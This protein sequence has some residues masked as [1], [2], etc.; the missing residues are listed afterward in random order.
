MEDNGLENIFC[1]FIHG[2]T[3]GDWLGLLYHVKNYVIVHF[4]FE[5]GD[6]EG[7]PLRKSLIAVYINCV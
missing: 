6:E 1:Q 5:S 2:G 4:Y 3:K 7:A